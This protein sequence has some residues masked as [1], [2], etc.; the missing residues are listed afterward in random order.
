[1]TTESE[2]EGSTSAVERYEGDPDDWSYGDAT[3]GYSVP[4]PV[5][6]SG[7]TGPSEKRSLGENGIAFEN[8]SVNYE[9][10]ECGA[11]RRF[12]ARNHVIQYRCG[13]CNDVRFFR[14]RWGLNR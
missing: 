10:E 4:A 11:V 9:C 12:A 1:M 2:S 5:R 3:V 8:H 6:Q 14:F 13:E 7:A